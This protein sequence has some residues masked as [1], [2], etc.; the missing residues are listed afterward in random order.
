[1]PRVRPFAL[2]ITLT[3]AWTGGAHAQPSV[4]S[5]GDALRA[6]AKVHVYLTA[7]T[8]GVVARGVD[9][10]LTRTLVPGPVGAAM[11]DPV[12]ELLWYVKDRKLSVLDLRQ[13]KPAPVVIAV[14]LVDGGGFRVV[15]DDGEIVEGG[16]GLHEIHWGEESQIEVNGE[17]IPYEDK[18]KDA[19]E[20]YERAKGEAG[21]AKITG[22]DWLKANRERKERPGSTALLV[23]FVAAKDAL[24]LAAACGEDVDACGRHAPFGKTAVRVVIVKQGCSGPDTDCGTACVLYDPA[25]KQLANLSRPEL[26][27]KTVAKPFTDACDPEMAP[28]GKTWLGPKNTVCT[29]AGCRKEQDRVI[30]WLDRGDKLDVDDLR[31]L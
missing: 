28:D 22:G 29:L 1:M 3:L 12:W 18:R 9:G 24:P 14:N 11:I 6:D 27:K 7:G 31:G 17:A 25:K 21:K 23:P 2:F 16:N 30:G 10:K 5:V 19:N 4:P 13:A 15:T 20:R 26:W 8:K